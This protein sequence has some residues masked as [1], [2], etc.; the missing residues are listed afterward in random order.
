MKKKPTTLSVGVDV[1]TTEMEQEFYDVYTTTKYMPDVNRKSA[2]K[3]LKS[4]EVVGFAPK[5]DRYST[6]I[7][8]AHSKEVFLFEYSLARF[9]L[10]P[11]L[12][13]LAAGYEE[14]DDRDLMADMVLIQL[15]RF[16]E[17]FAAHPELL[18]SGPLKIFTCVFRKLE[19]AADAWEEDAAVA[20][21]EVA[22]KIL[23]VFYGG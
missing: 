19:W 6:G 1:L 5:K 4:G 15:D 18:E 20:L 7:L 21:C 13:H 9:D 8:R 23:D 22:I 3:L 2:L 12:N 17:R 10:I 11:T 16:L 14:S